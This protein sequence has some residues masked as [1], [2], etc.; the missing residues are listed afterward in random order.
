MDKN[1]T[2]LDDSRVLSRL[3]LKGSDM[4]YERVVTPAGAVLTK[5]HYG[6]ASKIPQCERNENVEEYV[7]CW[8]VGALI[9]LLPKTL[10]GRDFG[11]KYKLR[12]E[13]DDSGM[14]CADYVNENGHNAI[15]MSNEEPA[16]ALY[17]MFET[18]FK[19]GYLP[20]GAHHPKTFTSVTQAKAIVAAGADCDSADMYYVISKSGGGIDIGVIRD[21]KRF[22]DIA[23]SDDQDVEYLPC[24]TVGALVNIMPNQIRAGVADKWYGLQIDREGCGYYQLHKGVPNGDCLFNYHMGCGYVIRCIYE[25]FMRLVS[26]GYLVLK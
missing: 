7:P 26:D 10:V 22:S 4:Y 9:K 1:Y 17:G 21:G 8:S 23:R 14:F 2:T 18:L 25:A 13:F 19:Q 16:R 24:W 12:I 5:A 3:G 6:D 15:S 20:E 11:G